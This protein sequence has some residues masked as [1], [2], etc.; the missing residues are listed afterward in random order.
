MCG[1][2]GVFHYSGGAPDLELV[3]R[4]RD[5]LRHRGPDDEGL[6]SDRDVAL[7]H[8]RLAI[9]DLSP[10][11]HQPMANE[12]STV[13]VVYNGEIY[14]WPRQRAIL[15]SRGHRFRGTSDT[16]AI[17]HLYEDHGT[18]FTPHLRGMFAFALY[19]RDRRRLV[20]GRDRFGVKPLYYHD[21]G[22]RIVFASELKALALDPSVPREVDERSIA[23]Y[24]THGHVPGPGTVWRGVRKLPPAHILV[25]D[26]GGVRL[27]RYWSLPAE[28]DR[29]RPFEHHRER[30][31]ELMEEAVRIRLLADVP[32]GAF[33]SGGID[34]SAVVAM[35]R[36][37]GADPIRTF[38]IGFEDRD[39]NELDH[40]RE[41]ARHLETDHHE[42]VVRPRALELLPKLVWHLDE[43]FADA[44]MIPAYHVAEMARRHVTVALS[45]DGGDEGLAGYSTH[46]WAARYAAADWVPA[47]LRRLALVPAAWLPPDHPLGRKLRR[48]GLSVVDRHLEVEAVCT[49]RVL[50]SMLSREMRSAVAGHD[51]F[52]A[53]VDLHAASARS[54]GDVP[55]LLQLDA[56][57]YMIDDV[58]VKVD[59]TSMA[60]SLEAREPLLDHVLQEFVA[61]IPFE[62]KLRG[63]V[64][65][66][67]LR[68]SLRGLLP[69]SV[70]RRPKHGFGVPL[71][72]WFEGGFEGLA[73]EVLLDRRARGRGWLDPRA[74][75]GLLGPGGAP[76]PHRT[77]RL[78]AMVCLEL[79]AQSYLDRPRSALDAPAER[80]GREAAA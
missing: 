56:Q 35:M 47:G 44:S 59:R 7:G 41:V 52:A 40:A 6:W 15:A 13:W 45:G 22:R 64:G 69:D 25:C 8:R 36:R 43:P 33:L 17:L 75:D 66:W 24:L 67:I 70:L 12:D 16:E 4:Q 77:R 23:D 46:A 1:I 63:Q 30:L 19:D 37:V 68:E 54:L 20:L 71:S 38:A 50:P 10:G 55:A 73:R 9:L 48:L 61:R 76:G 58:M 65:K 5:V 32:L 49:P 42:F 53:M 57:T 60:H 80:P 14:D 3:R 2:N 27:E 72:R 51:P 62:H 34:S 79:W 74:V 21:D 26:S 31:L 11:G 39:A 28:T 29:G 78:W 18:A